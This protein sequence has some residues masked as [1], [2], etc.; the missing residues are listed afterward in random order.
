MHQIRLFLSVLILIL[1][2]VPVHAQ[3]IDTK[4]YYRLTVNY[5]ED[6]PG[7]LSIFEFQKGDY[8]PNVKK[9]STDVSQL[10]RFVDVGKGYFRLINASQPTMSLALNTDKTK[11]GDLALAKSKEVLGQHWKLSPLKFDSENDGFRL[12]NRSQAGTCVDVL[13][14][15]PPQMVLGKFERSSSQ[16]WMLKKTDIK[17]GEVDDFVKETNEL[18]KID[19]K[20]YYRLIIESDWRLSPLK[21]KLALDIYSSSNQ[22]DYAPTTKEPSTDTSQLWRFVDEGEGFFSLINASQPD[23]CLDVIN[24][25]N[26]YRVVLNKTGGGTGQLW[27]LSPD[28]LGFILTNHWQ[29]GNALWVDLDSNSVDFGSLMLNNG[30]G[31][32][33]MLQKTKT[34]V[35]GKTE[36]P[37]GGKF[38]LTST[39]FVNGAE[40]P[41]KF[42]GEDGISPPLAWKGAPAGTKSFMILCTDPD[43]PSPANPDPNPFVHWFMLNIPADTKYLLAGIP[44]LQ[45]VSTPIGAV[46]LI[47]GTGEIGYIGP[48]PPAGSGKHRYFFT[49]FAMDRVHVIDPN[50]TIE[51][52]TK[53]LNSSVL[54]KAE[55]MGTYEIRASS[56]QDSRLMFSSSELLTTDLNMALRTA[57]WSNVSTKTLVQP[58]RI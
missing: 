10:W 43:A 19:P 17:I 21:R 6:G 30:S 8:A 35:E 11:K 32:V 24:D 2:F 45:Q 27:K 1:M 57:Q 16:L 54:A 14:G 28:G 52:F 22:G 47:N 56:F 48:M 50:L 5:S 23:M 39:S 51:E 13:P 25:S 37:V 46:Q 55:L 44:R 40:I 36:V 26:A 58:E 49:I 20:F 53:I 12:S 3:K 15:E 4:V 18:R 33:W 29:K 34:R 9:L 7:T 38:E 42:T 41:F 31:V